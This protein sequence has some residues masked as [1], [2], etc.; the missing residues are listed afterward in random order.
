MN[1]DCAKLIEV[2]AAPGN[3]ETARDHHVTWGWSRPPLRAPDHSE[4][5]NV[6]GDSRYVGCE[7]LARHVGLLGR[8][9]SK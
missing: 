7:P 6:L 9:P 2:S 3:C 4:A 1:R 5:H 8:E